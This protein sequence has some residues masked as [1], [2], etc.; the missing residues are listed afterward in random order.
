VAYFFGFNSSCF[1]LFAF[2]YSLL[3]SKAS[4]ILS[5]KCDTVMILVYFLITSTVSLIKSFSTPVLTIHSFTVCVP[6]LF[7][8][9]L[10]INPPI[11]SSMFPLLN[12]L[13]I[14]SFMHLL[15][16]SVPRYL[17]NI[18]PVFSTGSAGHLIPLP[19]FTHVSQFTMNIP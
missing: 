11:H 4:K 10:T 3:G 15:F 5:L 12:M 8:H 14:L 19:S 1:S 13:L 7:I 16:I 6:Y 17:L 18:V 2:H 9:S